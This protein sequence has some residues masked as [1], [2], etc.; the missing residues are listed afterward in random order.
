MRTAL[1]LGTLAVGL[2]SCTLT[3]RSNVGSAGGN[4]IVDVQPDR[5]EG[6]NYLVGESVRI[7]V[8]TRA[9]GYVTLVALQPN[10]YASTITRNVYVNPGTTVFPRPQDGETYTV[11]PPRGLQ[12][13]RV[14]FTR[15]RPA[16]APVFGG[17]YTGD[18]WNTSTNDYLRPYAPADRDIQ[19]TYFYIR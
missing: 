3:S 11:A 15:V 9:A 14:L 5:G 4:L 1:L 16:A 12:R 13:V 17:V 2:T 18:R 6:S 8:T 7:G 10:G 19:E